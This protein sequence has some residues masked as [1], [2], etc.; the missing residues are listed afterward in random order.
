MWGKDSWGVP[1]LIELAAGSLE[2]VAGDRFAGAVGET[3]LSVA[4]AVALALVGGVIFGLV[5]GSSR[6]LATALGA[7]L[8]VIRPIPAL[9]LIP[10]AILML[11]QGVT[12]EVAIAAFGSWWPILFNTSYGVRDVDTVALDAARAMG[13]SRLSR[14]VRVVLP[15]LLPSVLTGVRTAVPLTLVIVIAAEYLSTAQRGMG[16]VLITATSM[17]DMGVLW[18][19]ALVAGLLGIALGSACDVIAR[20][21]TPWATRRN[22]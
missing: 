1:G 17:G 10:V 18:C 5:M 20:S 15:S 2:L 21:L 8:E 11:G 14:L 4:V 16:G 12:M 3:V 19:T 13:C 22:P 7:P 9:A 6:F